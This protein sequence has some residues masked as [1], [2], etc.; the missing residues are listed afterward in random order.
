MSSYLMCVI[1]HHIWESQKVGNSVP[2]HTHTHTHT[3]TLRH[4]H[5]QTHTHLKCF[6]GSQWESGSFV[7]VSELYTY[8]VRALLV[9][10]TDIISHSKESDL[11]QVTSMFVYLRYINIWSVPH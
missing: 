1:I 11:F 5:T 8:M 10:D 6:V 3:Y 2:T 7:R 9:R 4:T